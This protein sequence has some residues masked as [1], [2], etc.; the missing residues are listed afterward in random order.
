MICCDKCQDKREAY[1]RVGW[2][3][4]PTALNLTDSMMLCDKCY[5]EFMTLFGGFKGAKFPK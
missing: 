4:T 2:A 1:H 3:D 5:K